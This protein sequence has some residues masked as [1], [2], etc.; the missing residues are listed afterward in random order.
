MKRTRFNVLIGFTVLLVCVFGLIST[1]LADSNENDADALRKA[2][3]PLADVKALM[4]DNTVAFGTSD[5][6]TSYAFQLQPVYSIPTDLGFNFIAR[7]II[8]IVGVHEG[9]GLPKLGTEPIGG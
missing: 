1:V 9:A 4:T 8:P 7:G 2:Q 6:Q 5:D 3:D